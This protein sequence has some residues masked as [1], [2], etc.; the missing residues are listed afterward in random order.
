MYQDVATGDNV[1]ITDSKVTSDDG[2]I[3]VG[4][5]GVSFSYRALMV[6]LNDQGDT[7]WT[8]SY[9]SPSRIRFGGVEESGSGDLY[10]T[11]V[12]GNVPGV[13]K[14][15]ANGNEIWA[16][17][18]D[19]AG[20]FGESVPSASGSFTLWEFP[21]I[22]AHNDSMV[23]ATVSMDGMNDSAHY[24]V[25]KI[26]PSGNQLWTSRFHYQQV[27][28]A[29]FYFQQ[30]Q[31]GV[32]G[33]EVGANGDVY[34]VGSIYDR[35]LTRYVFVAKYQADGTYLDET[36]YDNAGGNFYTWEDIIELSTGEL[37]LCGRAL[38][39]PG[40]SNS[41]L[42]LTKLDANLNLLSINIYNTSGLGISLKEDT[43]GD[44]LVYCESVDLA[45]DGT[46]RNGIVRL[47][48]ALNPL[49]TTLYGSNN[50]NIVNKVDLFSNGDMLLAGSTAGFSG[51]GS[52]KAYVVRADSNGNAPGCRVDAATFA[53]DPSS[54]TFTDL[55]EYVDQS[56]GLTP[57]TYTL[58]SVLLDPIDL[59]IDYTANIT[60][61]PC[62]GDQGII[63][64]TVTSTATPYSYQ[65]SNGTTGED[66]TDF[67]GAYDVL[68]RDNYGC[69]EDTSFN[70][71]DPPVLTATYTTTNVTCFGF[72]DGSIDLTPSGGTPGYTFDWTT[73]NTSEDLSGLSG[74]FYQVTITDT[75]GCE[76][77][78][79]VAVTEPQQL[80]AVILS[81]QAASC[82][83]FCDGQLNG[84]ATGGTVPYSIT[85]N[86][87]MAQ[88]NDT[89]VNLCA[90]QYLLTVTDNNGCIAY[91]N[92][93]V[94]EPS[95]LNGNI[96]SSPT[97]C[98]A[99]NGSA[100]ITPTGGT[101][102][103]S[104]SWTGGG[105]ND[106][107][108]GLDQQ[109]YSVDVTDNNGCT[110]SDSTLI[111]AS[112]STQE[113]C[114]VSVDTN[115][116]NVVNWTKPIAGNIA[117]YN[118]YRNIT[119]SYVQ[120]GYRDYDS[121]SYF[122][123]NTFGVDPSITSYRYKISV[124]DTCGNESALSAYHETIHLTTNV[125]TGG[126]V[127]LIWDNYEG[128]GFSFYYI[129]RD[130]TSS[131]NWE[132]ID[133]VPATN[134]TYTDNNVPTIGAD[135]AV[136]V[137][138][139][140]FCDATKAIGDFNSSRSNRKTNVAGPTSVSNPELEY[141]VFPNPF[142][143]Q[144]TLKMNTP[145]ISGELMSLN[146]QVIEQFSGDYQNATTLNLSG[147]AAGTYLVVVNTEL[148]IAK[149]L[150]TKQ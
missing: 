144:L 45:Y 34:L 103:Y 100:W 77:I 128:F 2:T 37:L 90:G 81:A 131:N 106:T 95:A 126:E 120:I 25:M 46:S 56:G 117:G 115:N 98:G 42:A 136:E 6:K 61:P 41:G 22:A 107:I 84:L 105:T 83:G 121:L 76:K 11:V 1:Q 93:D 38:S 30:D 110:Y 5:I 85:W 88:T 96:A 130:S 118:I 58:S 86:D 27:L 39:L 79:G 75:N 3:M 116:Q 99:S 33:L 127:N 17:E 82:N 125:G 122:I 80:N 94:F 138:T 147:L 51:G 44:V 134:F 52:F 55:P 108:T 10:V 123:D 43:N 91:A 97:E 132:I 15:D 63:D 141:S 47:D 14:F 111:E 54:L 18:W 109:W 28:D 12:R 112:V 32:A 7:L 67:S 148:G 9:D 60:T 137:V 68:I 71:V 26:D 101:S 23:I 135:Y 48:A 124:V 62:N 113:I 29:P 16:Q 65:W 89:A 119:G 59:G 143:D 21:H 36:V 53:N 66:L 129:L 35:F 8:K 133:S 149:A 31:G 4:S 140:T 102:P 72:A 50:S 78:V 64:L 104:Y 145:I 92:G 40:S 49:T 70:L 20:T 150:V 139:P 142:K 57:V 69:V 19:V 74:G 13:M 146:G 87:P 24:H 73:L 114:V